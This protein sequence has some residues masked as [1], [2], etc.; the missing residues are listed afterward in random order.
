[1]GV[2]VCL[3]SGKDGV[4]RSTITVNLGI[5]LS[6]LGVSTVVVDG[7][8]EGASF[9]ILLGVDPD[10][11]SLHDCLACKTTSENAVIEAHGVNA[12]VGGIG[13]EQLVDVS[14]NGFSN[15]LKELT[16]RFDIV[17]VDSP[18]GLGTEAVTIM[19]SCQSVIL[20][21]TPDINSVTN[22]LKTLAV[23]KKLGT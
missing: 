4:G 12:L 14:V 7:D 11:P 3:A 23:A 6:S 1:M 16:E 19:N 13:I 22:T 17:L 8:I 9:S 21:L 10:T 15:I 18:A 5:A 2:S 20:V